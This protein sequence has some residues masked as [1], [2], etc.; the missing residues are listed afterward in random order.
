V[1]PKHTDVVVVTTLEYNPSSPDAYAD[2][3]EAFIA[4]D[5]SNGNKIFL[6]A[7][8]YTSIEDALCELLILTSDL[9]KKVVKG[10]SLGDLEVEP[11]NK[12]ID[13]D[14]TDTEDHEDYP[15]RPVKKQKQ[16][17]SVKDEF[18]RAM[19]HLHRLKSQK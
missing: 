19:A 8:S 13:Q 14:D 2:L 17:Q 3:Y 11:L 7:I 4:E 9:V 18:I 10:V 1:H 5:R 15:K 12:S 6:K 16:T